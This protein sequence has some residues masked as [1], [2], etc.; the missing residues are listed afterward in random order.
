M[1]KKNENLEV[2]IF[3]EEFGEFTIFNLESDDVTDVFAILTITT[4]GLIH[5]T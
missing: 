2:I 5:S 1:D 3:E 4:R